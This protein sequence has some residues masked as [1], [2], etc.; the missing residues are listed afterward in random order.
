MQGFSEKV[1]IIAGGS[2]DLEFA[3]GKGLAEE[4]SSAA[5]LDRKLIGVGHC[6]LVAWVERLIC[7]MYRRSR[8]C[9]KVSKK[10]WDRL[11]S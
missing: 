11:A 2:E 10:D 8:I 4:G 3:E 6:R 1:L 9:V 7:W 5:S